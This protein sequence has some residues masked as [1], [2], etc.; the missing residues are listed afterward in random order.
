MTNDELRQA[1]EDANK[2]VRTTASD[3]PVHNDFVKHLRALLTEQQKRSAAAPASVPTGPLWVQR[4]VRPSLGEALESYWGAAHAEG[5]EGRSHDTE[6]RRADS[7]LRDVM[8]AVASLINA[9]RAAERERIT[10]LV[11]GE[12]NGCALADNRAY[13]ERFRAALLASIERPSVRGNAGPTA[14]EEA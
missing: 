14:G 9:E 3:S 7:A 1:I 13:V 5:A 6:D 12:P 11:R 4:P 2:L 10:S 8:M